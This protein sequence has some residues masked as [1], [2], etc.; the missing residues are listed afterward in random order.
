[1]KKIVTLLLVL[2][3]ILSVATFTGCGE[4]AKKDDSKAEATAKVTATA[5]ANSNENEDK[6][7]AEKD[8]SESESK[9]NSKPDDELIVG[10]WESTVDYG[11]IM[12]TELK[13]ENSD[14]KV[15][16]LKVKI[17]YEFKESGKVSMTLEENAFDKIMDFMKELYMDISEKEL[18]EA[19]KEM[20]MELEEYLELFEVSSVEEYV[21]SL[22]ADMTEEDLSLNEKGTY[23]FEDGKLVIDTDSS[24]IKYTYKLT[25]DSLK[26]TESNDEDENTMLPMTFVRAD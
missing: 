18:K 11:K 15:S 26:F 9:P 24:T 22:F 25:D 2:V 19:A 23:S 3:T 20:D 21:D 1:M 17:F 7:P 12:S 5:D 10:N 6:K 14:I 13:K 4:D 8:E 16:S